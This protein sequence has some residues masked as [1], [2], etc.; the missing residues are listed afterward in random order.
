MRRAGIA[1]LL[2]A[3]SGLSGLGR[4]AA[5]RTPPGCRAAAGS[6]SG[7]GGWADR[8]MHE[9]TGIELILI[10]AGSFRMGSG[11]GGVVS[12]VLPAHDVTI[13]QPFY[14]GR[15]EVTN[16]AYRRFVTARPEYDGE[17]DVDP[18]YD[19]YLLHFKGRSAMSAADRYP[20]VWVSWLNARAFCDWA[21]LQLP[22]EAQWEYACRAGTTTRYSFG[23]DESLL[24]QHAWA[25]LAAEHQTH[26][27]AAKLPNPWGLYDMHGNV[28][29]WCADDYVSRYDGAPTDGSARFDPNAQTKALRGG[30]WSTGPSRTP[31]RTQNWFHSAALGSVARFHVAA[32]NAWHDR[33]FRVVLPL[34][35]AAEQ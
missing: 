18:A 17:A 34:T 19:L 5:L 22:S 16:A 12:S 3:V 9:R 28:W 29:E 26:P 21:G 24:R 15:T 30:S 27:V 11:D 10:P 4:A 1:V 32:G 25:D 35:T 13:A 23:D 8:V 6:E 31:G 14:L 7:V 20:V 2:V 33:G